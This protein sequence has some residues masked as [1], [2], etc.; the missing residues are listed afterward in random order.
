MPEPNFK[1]LQYDQEN[2]TLT[3]ST[4][5]ERRFDILLENAL[6]DAKKDA[7]ISSNS[8]CPCGSIKL[9]KKCCAI[10]FLLM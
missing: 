1:I 9:F 6:K 3:Q 7:W 5:Y 10:K 4:D 8:L 2:K